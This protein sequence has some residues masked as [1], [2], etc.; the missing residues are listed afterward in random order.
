MALSEKR[1]ILIIHKERS[2]EKTHLWR[3]DFQE[4]Q[5]LYGELIFVLFLR[6]HWHDH[7]SKGFASLRNVLIATPMPL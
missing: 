1:D 7:K 2:F 3:N 4:N 6:L 5:L